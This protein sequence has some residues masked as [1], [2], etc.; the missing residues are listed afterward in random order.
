[1]SAMS[2]HYRI[3]HKSEYNQ[4]EKMNDLTTNKKKEREKKMVSR[5]QLGW[6]TALHDGKKF[7]QAP[8]FVRF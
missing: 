1:M 4:S 3:S 5:Q 6:L 8:G 2:A 7:W